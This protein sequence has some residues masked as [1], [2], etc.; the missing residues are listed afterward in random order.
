MDMSATNEGLGSE[1]VGLQLIQDLF[2]LGLI[3]V[4]VQFQG[5]GEV[6]AEDPHDRLRVHDVPAGDQVCGAVTLGYDVYEIFY[7]LDGI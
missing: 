2:C 4:D 1:Q 5:V 6:Q 3:C 7:G